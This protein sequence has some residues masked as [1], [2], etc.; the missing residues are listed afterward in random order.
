MNFIPYGRLAKSIFILF[1]ISSSVSIGL[2]QDVNQ[3]NINCSFDSL[4]GKFNIIS[5]LNKDEINN[6][7]RDCDL[8]INI[9]PESREAWE[10]KL[11]ALNKL[12]R[13]KDTDKRKIEAISSA[14]DISSKKRL[15]PNDAL[16][17]SR[18]G[19]L[20]EFKDYK[21][22]N[23]DYEQAISLNNSQPSYYFF[24]AY[25][26]F[27]SGDINRSINNYIKAGKLFQKDG[28][29]KNC[30]KARGAIN[31]ILVRKNLRNNNQWW[32]KC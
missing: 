13:T 5:K 30:K 29:R 27:Q 26:L 15:I 1:C 7:I 4:K 20:K 31:S 22:A 21:S 3:S 11:L 8:K 14:L 23:I 17:F 9:D 28:D 10:V 16:Y 6:L 25:S 12:K 2:A 19:L 24:F 32:F 18:A